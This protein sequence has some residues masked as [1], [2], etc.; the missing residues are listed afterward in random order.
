M[1]I[2]THTQVSV[3]SWKTW[4]LDAQ[5]LSHV[6][7][8]RIFGFEPRCWYFLYSP[9]DSSMQPNLIN[10]WHLVH[11]EASWRREL[12]HEKGVHAF[13]FFVSFP[14]CLHNFSVSNL[15]VFITQNFRKCNG[16]LPSP[17]PTLP[18]HTVP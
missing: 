9:D 10:Q 15:N 18:P 7:E 14:T 11:S 4:N 17:Y 2:Y 8:V 3:V 6:S 12:N 1:H 5:V 13:L 16:K